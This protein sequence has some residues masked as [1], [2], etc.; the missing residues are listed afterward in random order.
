MEKAADYFLFKFDRAKFDKIIA[1]I[2]RKFERKTVIKLLLDK[3]GNF[4]YESRE[5][6]ENPENVKVVISDKK[7]ESRNSF[8]YFKTTNRKFYDNEFKKAKE[9]GFFDA[10]FLNK[11]NEITEGAITNILIKK[12][13]KYI[14]PSIN[15]GVLDGCY[16]RYLLES[17]YN[18]EEKAIFIDDLKL[19]D[20]IYLVNSV[21]KLVKVDEVVYGT[22]I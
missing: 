1:E 3:W 22:L 7:I 21:R 2:Q 9:S 14:T 15:S 12:D 6:S 19:A 17:W 8:Q 20:E 10:I 4:K 18:I 11:N 5:Y 16:R 13:G